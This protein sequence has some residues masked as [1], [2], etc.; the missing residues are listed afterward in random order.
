[1]ESEGSNSMIKETMSPAEAR[2]A[3]DKV[4]ATRAQIAAM[5]LCPPW[6]HAAFGLVMGLLILGVG[7]PLA[8][9]VACMVLAMGLL[10]VIVVY[11]RR[12]YGMFINGYRKGATRPVTAALLAAMMALMFV[13]IGLREQGAEPWVP[14]AVAGVA[15][16]VA[17][18]GSVWWNRVFRRELGA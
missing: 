7:F 15:F 6:R 17:V 13:Q 18:A 12:R 8:M 3:L 14:F 9:Q 4:G 10:V 2:A 5:G 1:M 16:L 11:D